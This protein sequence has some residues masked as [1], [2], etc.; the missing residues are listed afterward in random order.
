MSARQIS[1]SSPAQRHFVQH[2]Q[3]IFTFRKWHLLKYKLGIYKYI[4]I[5]NWMSKWEKNRLTS[6][7]RISI[8]NVNLS[9]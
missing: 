2:M 5:A 3:T 1:P 8:S 9:K 4:F 7:L 6:K